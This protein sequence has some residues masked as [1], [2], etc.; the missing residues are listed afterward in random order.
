[1]QSVFTYDCFFTTVSMLHYT[2]HD[3]AEIDKISTYGESK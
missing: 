2:L 1:M 3:D